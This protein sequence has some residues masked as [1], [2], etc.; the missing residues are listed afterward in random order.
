MPKQTKR[1][2]YKTALTAAKTAVEA[3]KQGPDYGTS[4]FDSAVIFVGRDSANIGLAMEEV[5][6]KGF[7]G[8]WFGRKVMFLRLSRFQGWNRTEAAQAA[9]KA[10]KE[11]GVDADVYYRMD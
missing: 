3:L 7:E 1:E 10:L 6:I 11:A 2:F 5:G 9:A 8:S 4:N